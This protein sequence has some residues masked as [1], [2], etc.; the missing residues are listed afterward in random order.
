M[1]DNELRRLI[2]DVNEARRRVLNEVADLSSVAGTFQPSASEWSVAEILEHLVLAELGGINRM[3]RS[4]TATR[5]AASE[6]TGEALHRGKSIEEVVAATWQ[7][8]EA[9]PDV[10]R[11]RWKG[12]AAF[13]A[14]CLTSCAG[15]LEQL[16]AQLS[17]LVLEDVIYPHPISGPLD[18]RQRLEFLRFHLDRHR[19]QIQRVKASAGF[20]SSA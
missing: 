16:G 3:W 9:A 17:G 19:A 20:P 15:P 1:M 12:P 4:A 7:E 6:W 2:D 5:Q 11:P 13:W 14:A 10:A 8:R 18:A